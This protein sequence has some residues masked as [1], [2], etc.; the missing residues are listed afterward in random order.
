L[1]AETAANPGQTHGRA[2][3]AFIFI[4]VVLDMLALGMIIPVLP[5]LIEQFE[6]GDTASAARMIGIFGTVWAS[7]QFLAARSWRLSDHSAGVLILLSNLGLGLDY[8]MM[9]LAPTLGWLI[10]GRM[11]SGVTSASIVTAFAYVADVT[12]PDKRARSYGMM[13][14]AFGIGFVVGP[15]LGG[16]LGG[17]NPR[18]LPR[19]FS[20]QLPVRLVDPARIPAPECRGAFQKRANPVGSLRLLRSHPQLLLRACTFYNLAHRHLRPFVLTPVIATVD[21]YRWV[22]TTGVGGCNRRAVGRLSALAAAHARMGLLF[23]HGGFAIYGWRYGPGIRDG[24]TDHVDG[25]CTDRRR[26]AR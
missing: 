26:R 4:T 24:H 22:A 18:M 11:V 5:M 1:S 25:V 16:F 6:G 20:P 15:A 19:P 10:A 21:R 23:G 17:I 9:A 12:T 14:A 3:L 13:G 7:M 8:I 2:A